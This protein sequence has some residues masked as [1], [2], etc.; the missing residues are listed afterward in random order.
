MSNLSSSLHQLRSILRNCHIHVAP[1]VLLRMTV[2][3][4]ETAL[5][6]VIG[7]MTPADALCTTGF[8]AAHASH[9]AELTDIWVQVWLCLTPCDT[10]SLMSP[11]SVLV[12]LPLWGLSF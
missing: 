6:L 1:I 9:V 10:S 8:H 4:L 12:W 11:Q 2:T 7:F 3:L 5:Q